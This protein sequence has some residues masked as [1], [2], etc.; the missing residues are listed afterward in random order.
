ST[1]IAQKISQVDGVGNVFVNGSSLPAVRTTMDMAALTRAGLTLEDVRTAITTANV[2]RPKG[3]I[4]DGTRRWQVVA[5]DQLSKAD[6]YKPV[7]VRYKNGA[8]LRLGDLGTVTDGVQ[9]AF[10][11]GTSNGKRS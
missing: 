6:E 7:I 4:E 11:Y 8:A 3:V 5:S 2:N 1:V 10:N 9:D